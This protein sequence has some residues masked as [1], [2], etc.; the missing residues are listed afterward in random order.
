MQKSSSRTEASNCCTA[1]LESCDKW[2][3]DSGRAS[4]SAAS[5]KRPFSCRVQFTGCQGNDIAEPC[6]YED[7]LF[8]VAE[9]GLSI[10]RE[11]FHSSDFPILMIESELWTVLSEAFRRPFLLGSI[12]ELIEDATVD[13]TVV[14][15]SFLGKI[16]CQQSRAASQE[17]KVSGTAG[18]SCT[19]SS[20][21]AVDNLRY[22]P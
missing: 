14:S 2:I 7:T 15:P 11:P 16:G 12:L 13:A 8:S 10:L 17:S 19:T 1:Y 4:D 9:R 22:V 21:D 6:L 20:E 18:L 5:L 3:E